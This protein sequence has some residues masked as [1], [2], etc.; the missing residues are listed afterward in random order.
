MTREIDKCIADV[1]KTI[2][3][4]I[5]NLLKYKNNRW[6]KG[7]WN[8]HGVYEVKLNIS[9]ICR[10]KEALKKADSSNELWGSTYPKVR[11][12][13]TFDEIWNSY[14]NKGNND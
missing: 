4:E 2:T 10:I 11:L 7:Y 1:K 3:N 13:Q 8:Q 9:E 14:T 6:K 5:S 12:K